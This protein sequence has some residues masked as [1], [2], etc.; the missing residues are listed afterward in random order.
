MALTA[1]KIQLGKRWIYVVLVLALLSGGLLGRGTP[2]LAAGN[3][4][5]RPDG[6]AKT[7]NV[8]TPYCAIY[9]TAGREK[10]GSDHPRRIIGYFPS[11]RHGKNN[12]P[13]Y[14]AKDIPWD[15]ITH[16]NYAFAH[17]DSASKISVGTTGPTNPSTGMEWP[18]VAGAELD[19]TL[20]Y[21]GH[22]NLLTKYKRQHPNVKTL[23]SV[24]GW[25]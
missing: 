18:G 23:I 21:K 25:A 19:P 8:D 6:M 9:D 10:M 4:D 12:Q 2:T 3:E 15:K 17:I 20:P 11:W 14:L 22:F 7:P 13:Q 5:C 24:G 1:Q 16:I